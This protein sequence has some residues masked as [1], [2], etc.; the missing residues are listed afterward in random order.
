MLM[1]SKQ[2]SNAATIEKIRAT[3]ATRNDKLIPETLDYLERIGYKALNNR[4]QTSINFML[5]M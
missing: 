5:S 3:G 1:Q 4:L 2:Q